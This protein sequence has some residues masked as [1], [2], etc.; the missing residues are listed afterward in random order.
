MDYK[1]YKAT[2]QQ[3]LSQKGREEL[4]DDPNN[5]AALEEK[6]NDFLKK[7][8]SVVPRDKDPNTPFHLLSL[9]AVFHRTM[10]VGIDI[11]HDVSD[12][13]SRRETLGPTATR[14]DIIRVLTKPERR[15]YFG[16]WLIFF[17]M[18]F[19]FLDGSS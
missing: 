7:Y 10:L 2:Y 16:I 14:R 3:L 11:V 5:V 4:G 6:I 1:E 17:A 13:I 8:P 12:I 19:F 9:K 18:V 15:V